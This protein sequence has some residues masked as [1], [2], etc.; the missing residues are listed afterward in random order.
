[1]RVILFNKWS[2][3]EKLPIVD[4]NGILKGLITIKDIEKVI[5]FSNAAKDHHGRLLVGAAVEVK[6]TVGFYTSQA[7]VLNISQVH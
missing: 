6:E 4:D 5:E 1:M 3:I 2:I 7:L